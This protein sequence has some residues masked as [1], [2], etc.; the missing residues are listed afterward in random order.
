M[1]VIPPSALVERARLFAALE[2]ALEVGFVACEGV[3]RPACD[4]YLLA[5]A[6]LGR[7]GAV[8]EPVK[9]MRF[10]PDPSPQRPAVG[11]VRLHDVPELDSRL[12]GRRLPEREARAA[13]LDVELALVLATDARSQPLW[14][15]KVAGGS[16]LDE[17][18]LAAPRLESGEAL[19]DHLVPGRFLALLALVHYVRELVHEVEGS[20]W[21]PPPLRATFVIDDPNLHWRSY[22][23]ID[24]ARLAAHAADV[25]YRVEMAT[26]PLD[27]WFV[28]PP[29]ARVFRQ[30]SG[31]LGLAIHGND[32]L[33]RELWRPRTEAESV[34]LLS[35][36][37]RRIGRLESRSG[38]AVS[39]VMVAP[40]EACSDQTLRVLMRLGYDAINLARPFPWSGLPQDKARYAR[41]DED[42][43]AGWF[44]ADVRDDG[45]PI[46]MRRQ[47]FE[48]DEVALRAYLDQPL[49]FYGHASDLGSGLE[50]FEHAAREINSL[51][52]VRWC[53]LAEIAATNLAVRRLGRGVLSVRPFGRR[54]VLDGLDGIEEIELEWPRSPAGSLRVAW[55]ERGRP[56]GPAREVAETASLRLEPG[57][58]RV[59]L[60]LVGTDPVDPSA[61]PPPRR[62]AGPP[63][64]R[65]VTEARDRAR[66]LGA[67]RPHPIYN[68]SAR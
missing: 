13:E 66:A 67:L 55:Q 1:G 65:V 7:D 39:R 24:Y 11:G 32:H 41:S 37:L 59:E 43:L 22:G 61:V 9:V 25:G 44:P 10:A 5:G 58:S 46:L 51:P 6:P 68:R 15:R 54:V 31:Q 35:Q 33:S 27:A 18:A 47:L 4:G 26:I 34:A 14:V 64:R 62:M 2:P 3:G 19:R 45:F 38:V 20:G 16:Q 53:S 63:A 40:H 52:A 8:G 60:T 12:R 49:I 21:E 48:Y 30:H 28:Y 23:P 42:V 56:L 36:A 29:A 57:V 50:P 17:I